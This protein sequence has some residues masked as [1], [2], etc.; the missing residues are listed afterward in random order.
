MFS[1]VQILELWVNMNEAKIGKM[2][3]IYT[4]IAEKMVLFGNYCI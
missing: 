1:F 4:I 3:D 2:F